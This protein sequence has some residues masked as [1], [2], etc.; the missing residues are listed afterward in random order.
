MMPQKLKHKHLC[1]VL[2]LTIY[3]QEKL[4]KYMNRMIN[5]SK[6][7]YLALKIKQKALT[8]SNN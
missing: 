7:K 8:L 5:Y 6:N 3:L 2:E 1:F 4:N